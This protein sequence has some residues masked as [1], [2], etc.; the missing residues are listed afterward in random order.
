MSDFMDFLIDDADNQKSQTGGVWKVLIVDDDRFVHEATKYSLSGFTFLGKKIQWLSAYSA[1]EAKVLL[2]KE[3]DRDIALLFLDVV[4]EADDAGLQFA[5][6]FRDNHIN[7]STRIILRT[8]QPGQAPERQIIVNYDLHDYK[9]KTE[10]SS[11]KLFTTTVSALRAYYDMSRLETTKT[12]LE[13]I[14]KATANLF[15]IQSMYEYAKSVLTQIG[16]ILDIR[17]SGIICAQSVSDHSWEVLAESG[18]FDNG[19]EQII[20]LIN[21]CA[22]QNDDYVDESCMVRIMSESNHVRYAIYLEPI[23]TL[24]DIQAK[25]LLMFCTNIS[26]GLSNIKLYDSLVKSNKATVMSLAQI[27][28]T[29]DHET[30]E[31]VLRMAALTEALTKEL[32][33]RGI[34]PQEITERLVESIGL[35]VTLHDVGKVS[36]PDYILL[37]PGKLTS[38]E[39]EVIKGHTNL[40]ADILQTAIDTAG[41]RVEYLEIGKS[42]ALNHHERWDGR[43]YPNGLK[44]RDIPI[45]ARIVAIIDVFDALIHKRCY[46]DAYTLMESMDIIRHDSGVFFD[47]HIVEVF[48]EIVKDYVEEE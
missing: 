13:G 35:S 39:F 4:M 6:W 19:Y 11:D 18:K 20:N 10:L 47:P 31:H 42:I 26:I 48:L 22:E 25:M 14:I 44:G 33:E 12:G 45:E 29:R 32:F 3:Q 43:G 38:E 36:I 5:R 2:E 1:Q 37:K 30:G 8:G 40:G 15:R 9:T 17:S 23:D 46:K 34:Y 27:T 16:S 24:N 41:E 7:P 21:H 28:E